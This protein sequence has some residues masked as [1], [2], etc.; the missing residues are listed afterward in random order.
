MKQI[1]QR[2]Y[3]HFKLLFGHAV[4]VVQH[5]DVLLVHVK[6]LLC[7]SC[8]LAL[9]HESFNRVVHEGHNSLKFS[10]GESWSERAAN[11]FPSFS[12]CHTH[13]TIHGLTKFKPQSLKSRNKHLHQYM[14]CSSC[15][16]CNSLELNFYT[17]D[18][19][20]KSRL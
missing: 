8:N 1:L 10:S 11:V 3:T 20:S 18:L 17:E 5:K 14:C 12:S 16:E 4:E 6:C 7:F 9:F 19:S 2:Q 13:H 15:E